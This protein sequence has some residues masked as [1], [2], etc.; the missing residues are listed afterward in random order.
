[1]R[2]S[3]GTTTMFQAALAF[4]FIFA[5]FISLAIT[6][7]KVF[8]AKNEVLS[9]I[10]KYEGINQTSIELINNYLKNTG[11]REK[12]KCVVD[13]EFG[14]KNFDSLM[15]EEANNNEKYYYCLSSELNGN[16]VNYNV[17]LFYKFNLPILGVLITFNITGQTKSIKY[18][19][20]DQILK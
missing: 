12:N 1:M 14:I 8:K 4:T 11:Y 3:I 7:N 18:Y 2:Q 20:K 13:N 15:P 17:K 5:A 19:S 10:E 16:F 6:Y 9:I